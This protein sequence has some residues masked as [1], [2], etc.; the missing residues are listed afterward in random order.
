MSSPSGVSCALLSTGGC[1]FSRRS[2]IVLTLFNFGNDQVTWH[3]NHIRAWQRAAAILRPE[4]KL[5]L[6]AL[7]DVSRENAM[8]LRDALKANTWIITTVL[9]VVLFVYSTTTALISDTL[10]PPQF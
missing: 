4:E 10:S 7:R 1:F 3:R 8:I 2:E 5:V 9:A 6:C